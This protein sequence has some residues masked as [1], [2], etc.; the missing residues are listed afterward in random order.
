MDPR[1]YGLLFVDASHKAGW[2]RSFSHSCHPNC[3]VRVAAH[4]GKFVLAM[5]MIRFVPQ[6]EE[7]AFD[8]HAAT[9]SLGEYR[10][11]ICL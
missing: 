2:G 3:S 5:T 4:K 10:Q 1:G 9:E 11:A 7:L 8:Y 6:G